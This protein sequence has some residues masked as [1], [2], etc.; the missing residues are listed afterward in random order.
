M[1]HALRSRGPSVWMTQAGDSPAEMDDQAGHD[2]PAPTSRSPSPQYSALSPEIIALLKFMRDEKRE[3]EAHRRLADEHR[4]QA[5]AER[6]NQR[7]LEDSERFEALISRLTVNQAPGS[8]TASVLTGSDTSSMLPSHPPAPPKAAAQT[9]PIL[10]PDE[11]FQTFREWRR[12]WT[13]YSTM[14]DLQ[15]LSQ[16][17][18]LIQLRMCLSLEIQR[19][20]EHTLQVPPTSSLSVEEVLDVLQRHIKGQQNEALRRR[21]LFSCRQME[22]ESFDAFYVRLK[23]AS[24]EVDICPGH[25]QQCEETQLRQVILMGVKDEELVQ[26]LTSLDSSSSLKDVLT[27]CRSY[28]AARCA[29]SAIRAPPTAVRA[30]SRYKKDKKSVPTPSPTTSTPGLFC[31]NCGKQHGTQVCPAAQST[32]NSCDR[33]G[34]WSLTVR[35]PAK[36]VQCNVCGRLGHYDKCCPSNIPKGPRRRKLQPPSTR[37]GRPQSSNQRYDDS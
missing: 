37:E 1:S 11:T 32:C 12:R 5:E 19:V 34:H 8:N 26:R 36:R 25:H 23:R 7:R 6:D 9:P 17:K 28:E 27:I 30:V 3:D 29:T 33:K 31:N 21:E 13:D 24:E 16:P 15:S 10:K 22:G 4:R 14:V 35:C 20:L 2:A 18:Q